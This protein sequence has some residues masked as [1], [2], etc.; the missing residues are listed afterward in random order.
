MY[1]IY[2]NTY[3]KAGKNPIYL[4]IGFLEI[5]EVYYEAH[6][7]TKENKM[8]HAALGPNI[9]Y[10]NSPGWISQYQYSLIQCRKLREGYGP[11]INFHPRVLE[12]CYMFGCIRHGTSVYK[13]Q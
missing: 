6:N 1:N 4:D 2:V 10:G 11:P 8:F 12:S 13:E 3:L 7:Y 9:T 5:A